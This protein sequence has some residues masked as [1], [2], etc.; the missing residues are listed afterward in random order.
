MLLQ[1]GVCA[2]SVRHGSKIVLR[3]NANIV[4]V[5]MYLIR[6]EYELILWLNLEANVFMVFDAD[7]PAPPIDEKTKA[8]RVA[9]STENELIDRLLTTI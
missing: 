3:K 8:H 9:F 2:W 5:L 4:F 7:G 6:S 1:Q